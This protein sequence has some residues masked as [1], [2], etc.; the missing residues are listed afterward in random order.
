MTIL[1]CDGPVCLITTLANFSAP[2][3]LNRN[4]PAAKSSP[5]T[6][7]RRRGG[8]RRAIFYVISI[9]PKCRVKRPETTTRPTTTTSLADCR[10]WLNLPHIT[11]SQESGRPF[12]VAFWFA[13]R[14]SAG[15]W[16]QPF[17]PRYTAWRA[18]RRKLSCGRHRGRWIFNLRPTAVGWTTHVLLS[19]PGC[20]GRSF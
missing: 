10:Y 12:F 2:K 6:C 11:P 20:R 9:S 14:C 17:E 18:A 3:M 13:S 15:R 5:L 1:A 16:L 19:P 4:D 7:D 8:R